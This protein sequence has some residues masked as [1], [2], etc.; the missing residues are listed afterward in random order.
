M[1]PKII[2]EKPI[3]MNEL[4]EEIEHI[5]K[6]D[7][8]VSLRVQRTEEYLNFFARLKTEQVKQFKEKLT[9]LNIP[10]MKEEHITKII[11]MIPHTIDEL[12]SLLQGYI[13]T[14]SKDNLTKIMGVVDE[15]GTSKKK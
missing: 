4:K 3:N 11:D 15:F 8:E 12:K 7:K 9:K 1:N 14:V 2:N 13:I 10:R 6:R 5:K